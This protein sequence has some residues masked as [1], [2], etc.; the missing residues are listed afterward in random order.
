M[1]AGPATSA[2]ILQMGESTQVMIVKDI[3]RQPGARLLQHLSSR[4]LALISLHEPLLFSPALGAACISREEEHEDDE[5][6]VIVGWRKEANG[7]KLDIIQ[8][9]ILLNAGTEFS[10]LK[11][12]STYSVISNCN[13]SYIYDSEKLQE[14]KTCIQTDCQ[15]CKTT[16]TYLLC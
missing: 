9:S 13:S 7:I 8:H 12:D 15:V 5:Q 16:S 14:E 11:V 6:C 3:L 1:F 2:S 10:M 4:D